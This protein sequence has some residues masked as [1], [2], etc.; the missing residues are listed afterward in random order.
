MSNGNQLLRDIAEFNRYFTSA[1]SVAPNARISVPTSEWQA[2]HASLTAALTHPAQ[3]AE[4]GEAYEAIYAAW[5]GCGLDIVQGTDWRRFVGMLPPLYTAPPASQE[6]KGLG[7][8]TQAIAGELAEALNKDTQS[9]NSLGM[10]GQHTMA[11]LRKVAAEYLRQP[12][13]QEQAQQPSAQAWANETGLRQIECPS[14]GDLAVAYDPQQ[15]S[16]G[17]V[18]GFLLFSQRKQIADDAGVQATAD[19]NAVIAATLRFL[20]ERA[21]PKPEPMTEH[22]RGSLVM[23]HLGPAALAGDKMSPLDAFTLGIE[24]T[25]RFY[26]ITKGEA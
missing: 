25:E 15:P 18:P 5:K 4:G 10:L 11:W 22:Q 17:E 16:G 20:R 12:A 14:C 23:E 8:G 1:N 6:P 9:E 7:M 19:T 2:L 13:S 26:G 24:A 3:P 21:N